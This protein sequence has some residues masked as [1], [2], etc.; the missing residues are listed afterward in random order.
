MVTVCCLVTV[1]IEVD[2]YDGG[3][4]RTAEANSPVVARSERIDMM[5]ND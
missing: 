2:P 4:A 3:A 5:V 1:E